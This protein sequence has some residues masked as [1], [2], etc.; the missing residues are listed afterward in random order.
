MKF[1]NLFNGP[2]YNCLSEEGKKDVDKIHTD[3][4]NDTFSFLI[5][6]II[7]GII[8]GILI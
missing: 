1:T 3:W 7:M 4:M 5:M 8:I 6:G 2:F